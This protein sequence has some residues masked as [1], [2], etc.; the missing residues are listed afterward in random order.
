MGGRLGACHALEIPFVFGNLGE[1]ERKIYPKRSAETD[2]LSGKMMESW[3]SFARSGNPS[4]PNI[5]SWAP[6]DQK[7]R[8]TMIFGSE[9]KL[10]QDPLGQ[11]RKLWEGLL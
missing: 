11:E 2:A 3:T 8:N 7:E 9:V 10:S 1:K 6:Y 5:S 4:Y